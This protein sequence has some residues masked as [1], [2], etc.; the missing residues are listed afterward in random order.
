MSISLAKTNF[1][2][3]Q[4]KVVT[5][6]KST[7]LADNIFI[8]ADKPIL[9]K[10]VK[11]AARFPRDPI[12]ATRELSELVVSE[13]K[14]PI[15]VIFNVNQDMMD[16]ANRWDQQVDSYFMSTH[17]KFMHTPSDFENMSYKPTITMYGD[18]TH[19]VPQFGATIRP[20]G[21]G[22]MPA[23]KAFQYKPDNTRP[24]RMMLDISVGDVGT[25]KIKPNI[26]WFSPKKYGMSWTIDEYL[27]EKRET[28]AFDQNEEGHFSDPEDDDDECKENPLKRSKT[29]A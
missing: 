5:K 14:M 20:R 28:A 7:G 29:N 24:T 6:E 10:N 3:R 13:E 16:F 27:I 21:V 23:T 15:N 22:I 25:L 19:R 18:D 17:E 26:M 2:T 11:V 9:L 1:N 4:F 12:W 8:N